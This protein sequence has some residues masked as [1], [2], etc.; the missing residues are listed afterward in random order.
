[1]ASRP[2]DDPARFHGAIDAISHVSLDPSFPRERLRS[3]HE[4]VD[5]GEL[6]VALEILAENI[7][8]FDMPVPDDARAILLEIADG[9]HLDRQYVE[10]LTPR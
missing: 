5:A 7:N 2:I 1:M 3:I 8:D 6:E 10:L 4:M 9:V